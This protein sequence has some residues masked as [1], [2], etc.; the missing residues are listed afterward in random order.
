VTSKLKGVRDALHEQGK[1]QPG[2]EPEYNSLGNDRKSRESLI[3]GNSRLQPS[4]SASS[5]SIGSHQSS[6]LD[7]FGGEKDSDR[8]QPIEPFRRDSPLLPGDKNR[9]LSATPP[10]NM[11]S[12]Q[13]R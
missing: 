6:L 11:V 4:L 12:R 3:I 10:R 13:V 7:D 2:D 9:I 8:T 5:T 1:A